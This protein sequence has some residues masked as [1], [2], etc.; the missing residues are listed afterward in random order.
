MTAILSP[1]CRDSNHHKCNE[2]AWD[3]HLDKPTACAC[4]C[5]RRN[6]QV[7][8]AGTPLGITYG[9]LADVGKW[10]RT[11]GLVP[12]PVPTDPRERALHLRKH[13][14]TGPAKSVPGARRQWSGMR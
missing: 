10:L 5:H 3:E 1:D 14:N 12:E 6:E 7:T 13:R 9:Q 8:L 4:T 11:A 2:A